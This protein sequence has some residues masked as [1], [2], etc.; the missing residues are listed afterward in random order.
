MKLNLH[1]ATLLMLCAIG[2][3]SCEKKLETP[4]EPVKD[5]TKYN[6]VLNQTDL[7]YR[8]RLTSTIITVLHDGHKWVIWHGSQKGTMLHHPGCDCLKSSSF[9]L[10]SE[11]K[12]EDIGI[13]PE[14][15]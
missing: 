7:S 6:P 14:K 12:L 4:A 10:N 9:P 5:E 13:A 3:V 11:I 15:P 2:F 1:L 8:D